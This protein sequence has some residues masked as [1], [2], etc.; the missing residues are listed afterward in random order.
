[1]SRPRK[2]EP[3]DITARAVKTAEKLGLDEEKIEFIKA[4]HLH[5][6]TVEVLAALD[7]GLT[8]K[9]ALAVIKNNMNPA[10]ST[11]TNVKKQWESW[12][13]HGQAAQKRANL[14]LKKL[15]AGK[16]V[17]DVV[18]TSSTVY[19]AACRIID[20][21]DPVVHKQMSLNANIDIPIDL[22]FY[23]NRKDSDS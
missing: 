18:P 23:R 7:R 3:L 12:S 9:E 17:G 21:E 8:P 2:D 6:K 1:M 15:S 20:A 16:K 11:L 10:S 14:T 13:I 22:D 5:P 19:A 4:N